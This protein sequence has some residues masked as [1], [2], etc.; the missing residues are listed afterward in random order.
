[1]TET[2][3]RQSKM[4]QQRLEEGHARQMEHVQ[5]QAKADAER[6]RMRSEAEVADFRATIS[7]LEVDLMKVNHTT[8][9]GYG[10]LHADAMYSDGVFGR[11]I[12]P[13]LRSCRRSKRRWV[14]RSRSKPAQPRKRSDDSRSPSPTCLKRPQNASRLV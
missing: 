4:T 1:M 3:S 12:R 10:W 8:C 11:R 7:R 5:R 13:R 2:R 9:R 6:V 14:S